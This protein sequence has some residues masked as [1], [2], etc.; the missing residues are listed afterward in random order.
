[1]KNY[2][3]ARYVMILN[4]T[5]VPNSRKKKRRAFSLSFSEMLL[6]QERI[7]LLQGW[8]CWR[9]WM[10]SSA[11]AHP[12]V[13]VAS[14]K[15]SFSLFDLICSEASGMF[16][17]KRVVFLIFHFS[18]FLGA[19][20]GKLHEASCVVSVCCFFLALVHFVPLSSWFPTK[21]LK[22]PALAHFSSWALIEVQISKL[23]YLH[24]IF[25]RRSCPPRQLITKN[26]FVLEKKLLCSEVRSFG[27]DD[28]I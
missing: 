21:I 19:K 8:R 24:R 28:I 3:P 23:H 15:V 10:R 16:L 11:A 17:M 9:I 14:D 20:I 5:L 27:S 18:P 13:S 6:T 25:Y 26:G 4:P 7:S 12:N 1:M 2:V 22:L